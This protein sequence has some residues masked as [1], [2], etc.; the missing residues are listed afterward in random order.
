MQWI[1]E[2]QEDSDLSAPL[3]AESEHHNS[4]NKSGSRD[5]TKDNLTLRESLLLRLYE[6]WVFE[7]LAC[8]KHDNKMLEC[9]C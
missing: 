5:E 6:Q 7:D 2:E 4:S 8:E 1:Q 3:M 9:L